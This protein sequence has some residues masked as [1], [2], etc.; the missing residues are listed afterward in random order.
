MEPAKVRWFDGLYGP[1]TQVFKRYNNLGW[2]VSNTVA[3]DVV[4][5]DL[6]EERGTAIL[7]P[8]C[9]KL[10]Y[11]GSTSSVNS[12]FQCTLGGNNVYGSVDGGTLNLVDILPYEYLPKP[13][14]PDYSA[15]GI[16]NP[17]WTP[18]KVFFCTEY[19]VPS[20]DTWVINDGT[21]NTYNL[22]HTTSLAGEGLVNI[23]D[24]SDIY[25]VPNVSGGG[26]SSYKA[27]LY[28]VGTTKY[29]VLKNGRL[30]TDNLE[31]KIW[32][33]GVWSAG[34]YDNPKDYSARISS[35]SAGSYYD[36][37]THTTVDDNPKR[38]RPPAATSTGEP[39]GLYY[40]Q[41]PPYWSE[42]TVKDSGVLVK[43]RIPVHFDYWLRAFSSVQYVRMLGYFFEG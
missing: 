13:D 28:S 19:Y 23:A 22:S 7:R 6:N 20:G 30:Y 2:D 33:T 18:N 3:N 1:K 14:Y 39:I 42:Y 10:D 5:L 32:Y 36:V 25:Y 26:S 35:Y 31:R 43:G 34:S 4:D 21:A 41:I 24:S 17:N 12:I 37:I 29:Y 27:Y 15:D 40:E 11:N 8:G 16:M 9:T 38:G